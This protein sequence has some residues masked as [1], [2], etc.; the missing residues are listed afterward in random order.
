MVL[1]MERSLATGAKAHQALG[2]VE[3][4]Q[5]RFVDRLQALRSATSFTA[6]EW[7]RDQGRHGGGTRFE[8]PPGPVFNRGSVNV[9]QVHYDDDPQRRLAS[10]TALSTI[11]H[12]DP[13]RAPSMHLHVS[14]TH[15]RD[16]AGYWRLMADLNPSIPQPSDTAAF[17]AMLQEVAG[18]CY[19]EAS[20]QGDRYFYIPALE[21]HRGVS[22][23][24]LE[25]FD[26]GDFAADAEFAERFG[27]AVIDRYSALLGDALDRAE[28]PADRAA[29]LDYH[30]LYLFQVL[31]L[32]RGTTSG[33]LVHD[34]NDVGI[35]GSLPAAVNREL[36]VSW[37]DR[38]PAPQGSLVDALAKALGSKAVCEVDENAKRVLAAAVR[39]H[40]RAHPE[41]LGLQASGA[42]IPP[43]VANHDRV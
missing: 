9:S 17:E 32:D 24:Y 21:R 4:L 43:T 19:D 38:T 22:H 6:V 20:E 3:R 14:W 35:L 41:A 23:F 10:A 39:E 7:L 37:R 16:G 33:L 13:P 15:M 12:P 30:T 1:E 40:Y 18:A 29:Q 36:L 11:V 34:Q 5:R 27:A 28:Q 25:G 2:V 26:S 42:V 8:A 31:T